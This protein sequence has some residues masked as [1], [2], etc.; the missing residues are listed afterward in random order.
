MYERNFILCLIHQSCF[1]TKRPSKCAMNNLYRPQLSLLSG[2]CD[3]RTYTKA[4]GTK[5]KL[6]IEIF[7]N[8]SNTIVAIPFFKSLIISLNFTC[9]TKKTACLIRL[10]SF[11]SFGFWSSHSLKWR[12]VTW[13]A[14]SFLLSSIA[15]LLLFFKQFNPFIC[16]RYQV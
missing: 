1:K 9:K 15:L 8:L 4:S 14:F 5:K 13:Q 10:T 7:Y 16:M 3:C 11:Q 6:M 12:K 2:M